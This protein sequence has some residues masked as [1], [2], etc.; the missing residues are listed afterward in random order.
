MSLLFAE[1]ADLTVA[2]ASAVSRSVNVEEEG[3]DAEFYGLYC[4][5]LAVAATSI[6]EVSD[7]DVTF[8]PLKNE[9]NAAI[10]GPASATAIRLGPVPF[11]YWRVR[12]NTAETPGAVLKLRKLWNAY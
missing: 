6:I 9:L 3:F 2:A 5:T 11:K 12:L 10:I 8:V 4:P 7:D 1:M